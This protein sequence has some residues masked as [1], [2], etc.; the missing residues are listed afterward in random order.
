MLTGDS[1]RAGL[2]GLLCSGLESVHPRKDWEMWS[3]LV[4]VPLAWPG[5]LGEDRRWALV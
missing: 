3:R 4:S 1:R 2:S 5:Y